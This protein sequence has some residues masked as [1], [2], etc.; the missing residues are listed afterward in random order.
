MWSQDP[1]REAV[2]VPGG[3]RKTPMYDAWRGSRKRRAPWQQERLP[4]RSLLR[5]SHRS[6]ARV[7]RADQA[8]PRYSRRAG[9]AGES[10]V[11]GRN[12]LTKPRRIGEL[13][14]RPRAP[15]RIGRNRR[16]KQPQQSGEAA[17]GATRELMPAAT[18][19][20]SSSSTTAFCA[21]T[22]EPEILLRLCRYLR[23]GSP[24]RINT[25]HIIAS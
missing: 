11:N 7:I 10:G 1:E 15:R 14:S 3:A 9:I 13:V 4:A 12:G 22:V 2:P 20:S 5:R 6:S 17:S 16:P 24:D 21:K 8:R 18:A 19:T 23:S 25:G